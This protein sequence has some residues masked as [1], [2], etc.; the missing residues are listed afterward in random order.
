MAIEFQVTFDSADP[1][2]HAA[3][4]AQALHYVRPPSASIVGPT[5]VW[6]VHRAPQRGSSTPTASV[7]GC[8]SSRCPSRRRRRIACT[9]TSGQR[10]VCL[11]RIGRARS[12]RSAPAWSRSAPVWCGDWSPTAS[13]NSASSCRTPRA[14]SSASTERRHSQALGLEAASASIW[15]SYS[16][17]ERRAARMDH[18]KLVIRTETYTAPVQ[19]VIPRKTSSTMPFGPMPSPMLALR[20][21]AH[22]RG[23]RETRTGDRPVL[24]GSPLP[25]GL[26]LAEPPE[27]LGLADRLVLRQHRLDAHRCAPFLDSR[28]A[29]S[30]PSARKDPRRRQ[31]RKRGSWPVMSRAERRSRFT[32]RTRL[33]ASAHC[34]CRRDEGGCGTRSGVGP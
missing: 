16:R 25:V 23:D 11:P 32:R 26:L 24:H 10:P 22:N 18:T 6:G 5:R 31:L 4:W 12:S 7:R 8:T 14:T 20:L 13:T 9:S 19:Q 21:K 3:F 27:C 28:S 29:R 1:G 17:Q 33:L 15:A 30:D 34:T 2:A